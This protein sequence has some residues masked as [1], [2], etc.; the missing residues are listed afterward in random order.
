MLTNKQQ[1]KALHPTAYSLRVASLVPAFGG[2]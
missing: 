1:N 2:G